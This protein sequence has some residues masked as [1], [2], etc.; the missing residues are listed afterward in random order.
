M[1]S[2]NDGYQ[3]PNNKSASE[4]S[5]FLAAIAARNTL[6]L[7]LQSS[8][9]AESSQRVEAAEPALTS[10]AGGQFIGARNI[11]VGANEADELIHDLRHML[12]LPIDQC[13][14]DDEKERLLELWAIAERCL[15]EAEINEL[16]PAVLTRLTGDKDAEVGLSR[17]GQPL[18]GGC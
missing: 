7:I 3:P 8:S 16:R 4:L 11:F 6:E 12:A 17:D 18:G 5:Q 9:T 14:S 2:C 10:K 1:N 15:V 13:E